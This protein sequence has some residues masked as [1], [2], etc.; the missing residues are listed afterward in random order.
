[1][2][3]VFIDTSSATR[4]DDLT[5]LEGEG[6]ASE[7]LAHGRMS[8]RNELTLDLRGGADSMRDAGPKWLS[9]EQGEKLPEYRRRLGRTHLLGAYDD[10]IEKLVAKP[11]SREITLVG[12]DTLSDMLMRTVEDPDLE[13]GSVTTFFREGF[14][15]GIDRGL[16]H[17]LVEFPTVGE[18]LNAATEKSLGVHPYFV[19]VDPEQLIGARYVRTS[20]GKKELAEIRIKSVV[21]EPLDNFGEQEVQVIRVIRAPIAAVVDDDDAET[22]PGEPGTWEVWRLDPANKEWAIH[23]G[24]HTHTYPGIPLATVYYDKRDELE[25]RPPLWRLAELNLEHWQKKS[26]QDNLLHVARV[27]ILFRSGWSSAE[28]KKPLV[29]GGNRSLGSTQKDADMRFVEHSGKALGAGQAD[30][31]KIEEQME[32]CGL[33]P[34]IRRASSSL[35]TNIMVGDAKE[36]NMLQAW[37]GVT[38]RFIVECFRI[39]GQWVNEDLSEEFDADIFDEFGLS[40]RATENLAALDK[41]RARGDISQETYL[42]ELKRYAALS[43]SVDTDEEIER[44]ADEGPALGTITED[45]LPEDDL[46][47]EPEEPEEDETL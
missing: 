46:P 29:V 38:E 35:A 23:E 4:R 22:T 2:T 43:P 13:G 18:T 3:Q 24:P 8:A 21:T 41:A 47:E 28:L 37:A 20:A 30:L 5:F 11:F 1:M 16:H 42:N 14:D 7:S 27:P 10:C 33:D 31:D 6:V 40:A 44:T 39:A 45:D 15:T 17:V 36:T 12:E 19:H 26:D 25:A 9:M 32:R 34:L